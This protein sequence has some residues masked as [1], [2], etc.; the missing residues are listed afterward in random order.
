VQIPTAVVVFTAKLL[1]ASEGKFSGANKTLAQEA[2]TMG[3]IAAFLYG[4]IAYLIFF[5]TFLYAIAF[6]GNFFVPKSID[7]GTGGFSIEALGIDA[8][9]LGLFAIQHSVM[10]RQWFKRAWTKLIPRHIERSTYVLLASLCLDLLYWQWRP[11]T[12]VVWSVQNVAGQWMLLA[13]FCLGWLTVLGSTLM[14][15]HADLFGLRQVILYLRRQPYEPIGFKTPMLYQSVRHPIYL[16]FLVA[17]WATPKMTQGHLLFSIATTGYILVAIQF[18]EHDLITFFG[19]AYRQY[20][21]HT[22]MLLPFGKRP[23]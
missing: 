19:D 7:S 1:G 6:V 15:S 14:V 17:F 10:A 8:L 4:I 12:G 23:R 16:G 9:L 3:R 5:V 22:P 13:L 20:R 18:E 2:D 21:Q 11:M